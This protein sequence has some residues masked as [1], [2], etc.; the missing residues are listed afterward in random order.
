MRPATRFPK[1]ASLSVRCTPFIALLL[2]APLVLA[3]C[4]VF[5]GDKDDGGDD[6]SDGEIALRNHSTSPAFVDIQM[7]GVE[8][9]TMMSSEDQLD[10]SPGF[11]YAGSPDGAGLIENGDGTYT[12]VTNY[13]DNYSIGRLTF[14]ATFKPV[15]GE[16]IVDSDR[17]RWRLCSGTLATPE[18]HGFGPAF[19]SAGESG[20]ES[21][22]HLVDPHGGLNSSRL[23]PALGKHSTENAVPLPKTA[24]P[25][26]TTILIGEDESEAF[27]AYDGQLHL[28]LGEG[29]GNLDN[30]GLYALARTDSVGPETEMVAGQSY[31]VEF[32][33][34]EDQETLSGDEIGQIS[35]EELHAI[36]FNRIE[37]LDYRKDNV[38]REIYFNVTGL[39][40]GVEGNLGG[41]RKGRV[42]RLMMDPGNPLQGTLEVIFDGD[43][44]NNPAGGIF[45]NPDNILVTEN[46]VYIQEDPNGD[47]DETH[48][49]YIYQH[50]IG[51][52]SL[53]VVA[54]VKPL[55]GVE[56]TVPADTEGDEDDPGDEEDL[57]E[58]PDGPRATY[59]EADARFGSWETGAMLDISDIVGRE[60]TFMLNIQSH[61]WESPVFA[62]PDGGARRASENEGGQTV[63]LTGLPR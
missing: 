32:R 24:Y 30:G 41:T 20:P 61:G 53:D 39:D 2:C 27:G 49:A 37:D 9:F 35:V 13:E 17:G 59:A 60:G 40:A 45:Q 31:D 42:Y 43:D 56:S 16:Y 18:E 54:E 15:A 28:Y 51:T 6:G 29:V 63:V 46:Y 36:E 25:G 7:P 8:V 19:F 47:G 23:L 52:H 55:R 34:V 48:D 12:F 26:M 62:G 33:Q 38:G 58:D 11:T 1:G 4:D 57:D 21:Q 14:D 44:P 10:G 3:G 50:E 5:F 22:I